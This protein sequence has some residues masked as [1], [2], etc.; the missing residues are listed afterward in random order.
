[1]ECFTCTTW[2][3]V[4]QRILEDRGDED[5]EKDLYKELKESS[6]KLEKEINEALNKTKKNLDEL[7]VGGFDT[8]REFEWD[9]EFC[10]S[11]VDLEYDF[12]E[13]YESRQ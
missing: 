6:G 1:M 4:V 13:D 11:I 10:C 8:S 9:F 5:I 2:E 3:E 7:G 12:S